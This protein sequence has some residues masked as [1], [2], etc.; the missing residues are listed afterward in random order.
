MTKGNE[1]N[2]T[3]ATQIGSD[4]SE[5]LDNP[6]KDL[7]TKRDKGLLD[8]KLAHASQ[9]LRHKNY[10]FIFVMGII[11]LNYSAILYL[12]LCPWGQGLLLSLCKETPFALGLPL[13]FLTASTVFL[14]FFVIAVFGKDKK[15]TTTT[16]ITK[17]G[18][19]IAE[20]VAK[21]LK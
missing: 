2:T 12:F 1:T 6:D 16:E 10:L 7:Q 5:I 19:S 17:I 9:N 3:P 18:S 21:T 8:D 15:E 20:I 14:V 4:Y 13:A 11:C